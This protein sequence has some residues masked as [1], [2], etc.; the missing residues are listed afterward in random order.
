MT[1]GVKGPRVKE[2][3]HTRKTPDGNEVPR[4]LSFTTPTPHLVTVTSLVYGETTLTSVCTQ[5]LPVSTFHSTLSSLNA[6]SPPSVST[7]YGK[8]PGLVFP[9]TP[10]TVPIVASYGGVVFLLIV[11]GTPGSSSGGRVGHSVGV[12]SAIPHLSIVFS[13]LTR[14]R[15]VSSLQHDIFGRI[16]TVSTQVSWS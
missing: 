1:F 11:T 16:S 4:S 9:R 14:L 8:P 7:S 2:T 12:S 10:T 3:L 6:A 13:S 5:T 15:T